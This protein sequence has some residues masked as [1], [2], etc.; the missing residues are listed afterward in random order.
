MKELNLLHFFIST[1]THLFCKKSFGFC[2][3]WFSTSFSTLL[4]F[5]FFKLFGG[6]TEKI[7]HILTV[8]RV[9]VDL[10]RRYGWSPNKVWIMMLKNLAAIASFSTR[11][12]TG[13]SV[14]IYRSQICN[15]LQNC[16]APKY[17]RLLLAHFYSF[18]VCYWCWTIKC[19]HHSRMLLAFKEHI[20]WNFFL[21]IVLIEQSY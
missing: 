12:S 4:L 11:C 9:E 21:I 18:I 6:V 2:C 7:E 13:E 8:S 10:D 14:P 17:C 20:T 19:L 5:D 16:G 3:Y 1:T 15:C